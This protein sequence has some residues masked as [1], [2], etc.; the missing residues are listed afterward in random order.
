MGTSQS[1]NGSPSGVPMVPPWV[2]DI[3]QD[4]SNVG[5]GVDNTQSLEGELPPE[6][7]KPTMA[8]R[9][10]F[11]QARTSLGDFARG[12][13]SNQMKR[14]LGHYVKSGYGGSKI[15]TQRMGGTARTAQALFNALS[16]SSQQSNNQLDPR[17]LQG[18]NADEVMDALVEAVAPIDGSL[19][20]EASRFSVKD[21]LSEVLER[22]PE[23]DLTDLDDIQREYAIELFIAE[24]VFRRVDLD[25]GK[26]VRDKAPSALAG[27]RRMREI[28]DYIRETIAS[29]LRSLKQR[30]ESLFANNISKVVGAAINETFEIFEGYAS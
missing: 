5:P 14:G 29:S 23:A 21:A 19:D 17:I 11:G 16:Q 4:G 9:G 8:P 15:A 13:D 12:G 1:S 2:P 24:D 22:F 20:T 28:K 3:Q 26:T 30:G 10:R 25:I 7:R 6:Q 27:M 18:K